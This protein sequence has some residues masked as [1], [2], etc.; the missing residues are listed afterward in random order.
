MLVPTKYWRTPTEDFRTRRV[1]VVIWAN[2]LL[3]SAITAMQATARRVRQDE[4][5]L[6]VEPEVAPL[7]EVFRLQGD[8]ELMAAEHR[9][10]PAARGPALTAIVLAAGASEGF[11]G[12]TA[13]VPK[14]MLKVQG[15]P[16]LP[17]LLDDFAHFGCRSAVVVR[18]YRAEAIEI[19]G[20][21]YVDNPDW[22]TTGEAWSLALAEEHLAPGTL[23]AFGDIVLK[24]HIV[25]AL[26]GGG[27]G[28]YHPLGR[29]DA[30]GRRR[31]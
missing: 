29:F 22:A 6:N 26:L 16:I 11:A 31:A 15:R 21:H 10:L 2:H 5:L 28:R 12:L 24:R 3:R 17:R 18:G 1:S 25:Q 7:H 14:A 30:C 27:G 8:D 13:A 23:V 9:Y 20:A 19:P 4:S